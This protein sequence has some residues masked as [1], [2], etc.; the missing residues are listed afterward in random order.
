MQRPVMNAAG[1]AE[2]VAEAELAQPGRHLRVAHAVVTLHDNMAG[3]REVGRQRGRQLTGEAR[4]SRQ[5]PRAPSCA[6]LA[7]H[8]P[9]AHPKEYAASL[10]R[11]RLQLFDANFR[12]LI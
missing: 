7:T 11:G 2:D 5:Q 9:H 12:K 6:P 3:G 10:R 8:T 4:R 1:Q